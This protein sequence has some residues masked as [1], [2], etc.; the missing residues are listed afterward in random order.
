M[1]AVLVVGD[2]LSS[3][4]TTFDA[5]DWERSISAGNFLASFPTSSR[6]L[7]QPRPDGAKWGIAASRAAGAWLWSIPK[8]C[9]VLLPR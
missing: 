9:G 3:P 8:C 6:E 7:F 5:L 4:V 2:G 1:L